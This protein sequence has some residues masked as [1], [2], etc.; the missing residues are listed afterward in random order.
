MFYSQV[1]SNC[2]SGDEIAAAETLLE[3]VNRS[4]DTI[5]KSVDKIARHV[6]AEE[7]ERRVSHA[8]Q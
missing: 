6:K 8:L 4:L 1:R 5:I 3:S 7:K 2:D